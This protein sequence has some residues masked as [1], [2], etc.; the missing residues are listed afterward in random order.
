MLRLLCALAE[1]IRRLDQGKGISFSKL[2][3]FYSEY[4]KNNSNRPTATLEQFNDY[5]YR[6]AET[7]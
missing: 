4:I 2:N 7:V 1:I 3:Q 5:L 6:W